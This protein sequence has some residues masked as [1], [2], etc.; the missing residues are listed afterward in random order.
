MSTNNEPKFCQ[1]FTK[2]SSKYGQ[3][4]YCD[5]YSSQCNGSCINSVKLQ[6]EYEKSQMLESTLEECTASN[7]KLGALLKHTQEKLQ[8]QESQLKTCEKKKS[9]L[10]EAYKK[11]ETDKAHIW[12]KWVKLNAKHKT[13]ISRKEKQVFVFLIVFREI[14]ELKTKNHEHMSDIAKRLE[15]LDLENATL[16]KEKEEYRLVTEKQNDKIRHMKV[17][18]EELKS[19]HMQQNYATDVSRNERRHSSKPRGSSQKRKKRGSSQK[20]EHSNRRH[21]SSEQTKLVSLLQEE[22]GGPDIKNVTILPVDA[23]FLQEEEQYFVSSMAKTINCP[24]EDL[25]FNILVIKSIARIKSLNKI[26]YMLKNELSLSNEKIETIVK[27]YQN[28]VEEGSQ[29]DRKLIELQKE[30]YNKDC[31]NLNSTTLSHRNT[32]LEQSN[33]LYNRKFSF[34]QEGRLSNTVINQNDSNIANATLISPLK[35]YKTEQVYTEREYSQMHYSPLRERHEKSRNGRINESQST[36]SI[37][38]NQLQKARIPENHLN[39]G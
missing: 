27:K 31:Y 3:K 39:S 16:R 4:S 5:S 33:L 6:K 19:N 13:E 8:S 17:T 38:I 14:D 32:E 21:S 29:S 7:R 34:T 15:R 36:Q 12:E 20:R 30:Q 18:V 28:A 2:N 25:K 9:K 37:S 23:P 1:K 24:K 26:C 10:K 11:T 35:D 22:I